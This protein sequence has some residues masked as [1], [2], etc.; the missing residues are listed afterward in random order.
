[1]RRGVSMALA[2]A[3][4]TT[5]AE[6][7]AGRGNFLLTALRGLTGGLDVGADAFNAKGVPLVPAGSSFRNGCTTKLM[8]AILA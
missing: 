8:C 3:V 7:D 4:V 6:A 2:A 1:M 5:T